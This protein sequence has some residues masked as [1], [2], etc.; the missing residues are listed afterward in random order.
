MQDD[1][2]L[3]LNFPC[4]WIAAVRSIAPNDKLFIASAC[5]EAA[6]E[7]QIEDDFLGRLP[8]FLFSRRIRT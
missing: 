5:A 2:F 4:V 8:R 7:E 6:I 1:T 3:S